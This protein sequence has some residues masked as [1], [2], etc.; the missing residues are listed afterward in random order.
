MEFQSESLDIEG[1]SVRYFVGGDGPN[2]IY[3]H[4][5]AGM[6][7]TPPI[8]RWARKFRVWVPIVP[9]FDGTDPISGVETMEDLAQL[10]SDFIA[11]VVDDAQPC[12]VVGQSLGGWL[13]AWLAV[14]HP[15]RIDQL[16]LSSPA[17]FRPADAPPLSFEPETF[18]AQ[19]YAHPERRPPDD[20]PAE[21][22]EG[23]RAA[24]A[25]YGLGRSHDAAL[26]ERIG[27]IDCLTLI[28]HGTEDVR[29]PTEAVWMLRREIKHAQLVYIYDAA[30]AVESDQPE[31][32]GTV[33]EDFL[34]RGEAFIVNPGHADEGAPGGREAVSG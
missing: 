6:R 29:V 28:L 7:F 30:H 11:Q 27:E 1:G 32:V 33:V 20:K 24:R 31:R 13:G 10:V 12:D 34:L 26:I 15:E 19:L 18:Q 8:E 17:G 16:V 22:L 25:R 4:P 3:L 2:L 21:I 23:N 5:A 14:L 9:G